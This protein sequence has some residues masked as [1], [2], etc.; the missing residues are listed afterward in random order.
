MPSLDEACALA[1]Q[2]R[3]ALASGHTSQA[4]VLLRQ[5]REIFA[6]IGAAEASDVHADLDAL[7]ARLSTS[8]Y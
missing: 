8:P 1:G 4:G 6:R 5:A 7:I 3:C 2:G